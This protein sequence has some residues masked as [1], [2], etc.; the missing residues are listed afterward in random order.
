M[1]SFAER[2]REA[3]EAAGLQVEELAA[4][5]ALAPEVISRLEEGARRPEGFEL[6]QVSVVFG[7][8]PL[9]FLKG[10]ASRSQAALLLKSSGHEGP[11]TLARVQLL[12][13]DWTSGV[14]AFLRAARDIDEL[15]RILAIR[16]HPLATAIPIPSTYQEGNHGETLAQATRARLELGLTAIPSM[17]ALLAKCGVSTIWTTP[18]EFPKAIDGASVV[19]PVPVVLVNLV[20]G[21]ELFW[22]SRMTMAHELC[23]LLFDHEDTVGAFLSPVTGAMKSERNQL[24]LGFNDVERRADAFAACLLAPSLG[25]K[26]AVGGA[27]PTSEEAIVRVGRTFGVGA[28]VAINRIQDV[29]CLSAGDRSKLRSNSLLRWATEEFL[30]DSPNEGEIGVG[31]SEVQGL[32]LAAFAKRLIDEVEV[33]QYLGLLMTEPLPDVSLSYERRRPVVDADE[34]IRRRAQRYLVEKK[35]WHLLPTRVVR[36]GDNWVVDIVDGSR[37][38]G[39]SIGRLYLS[40]AGKVLREVLDGPHD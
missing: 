14:G 8:R 22:R 36:E 37:V 20:G 15:E 11:V 24:P 39:K 30:D 3:R 32:A 5:T 12:S 9:D 33:R 26:D 10:E 4:V 18:E 23:H 6:E 28:T 16:R 38:P 31:R 40:A 17:R 21:R 13:F 7:V 2:L 1:A 19:S 29:F 34:S 27:S 25:V 35:R